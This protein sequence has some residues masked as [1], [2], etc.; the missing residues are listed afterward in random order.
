MKVLKKADLSDLIIN[1]CS[2]VK[3]RLWICSP[4]VGGQRAVSGILGNNY[5]TLKNLSLKLLVDISNPF[6]CDYST[7][8]HLISFDFNV[9]TLRG[10]HAKIYVIDDDV[11]VT[12]AN[13][14]GLAFEKRTEVGVWLSKKNTKEAIKVF[15]LFYKGGEKVKKFTPNQIKKQKRKGTEPGEEKSGGFGEKFYNI[16]STQFGDFAAWMKISGLNDIESRKRKFNPIREVKNSFHGC[17]KKPRLKKGEEVILTRMGFHKGENDHYIFGRAIVD[18]PFRE[19]IDDLRKRVNMKG[20][21]SEIKNTIKRWPFGF[22]V[23]DVEVINSNQNLV[24]LKNLVNGRGVELIKP[25]SLGQQSHVKLN[26][27]QFLVINRELEKKFNKSGK[28]YSANPQGIW[29]NRILPKRKK[30]KKNV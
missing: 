13:L 16:P 30:L 22:W 25:S 18:I 28:L 7:L 23:K 8:N 12:S 19:G 5:R 14:T 6:N 24:W 4:Y 10:L 26:R 11:I 21:S 2:T 27:E 1:K 20:L 17:P 3:K 29:I 9:R 15:N